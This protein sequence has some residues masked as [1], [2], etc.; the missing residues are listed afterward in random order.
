MNENVGGIVGR[1]VSNLQSRNL[2]RA[3]NEFHD[4]VEEEQQEVNGPLARVPAQTLRAM[5]PINQRI[6]NGVNQ[7]QAGT[8]EEIQRQHKIKEFAHKLYERYNISKSLEK[9]RNLKT[10]NIETSQETSKQISLLQ[11]KLN[12]IDLEVEDFRN[13]SDLSQQYNGSKSTIL[14]VLDSLLKNL[15]TMKKEEHEDFFSENI[16]V[17]QR[18]NFSSLEQFYKE[19]NTEV[20]QNEDCDS[21]EE[22]DKKLNAEQSSS[23]QSNIIVS[24]EVQQ[25]SYKINKLAHKLYEHYI[26]TET[27]EKLE[28]I[29]K[30]N[31]KELQGINDRISGKE[32]KLMDIDLQILKDSSDLSISSDDS[33]P[34][35]SDDLDSSICKELDYLVRTLTTECKTTKEQEDF[36]ENNKEK[37]QN[38]GFSSLEDFYAKINESEHPVLTKEIAEMIYNICIIANSEVN[39]NQLLDYNNIPELKKQ[40]DKFQEE[41]V[42][43]LGD[44]RDFNFRDTKSVANLILSLELKDTPEIK[45]QYFEQNKETFQSFG[46][47]SLEN[48]YATIRGEKD[49]E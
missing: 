45:K 12:D 38:I 30:G 6:G 7:L 5:I 3:A 22:F 32:N 39:L 18:F 44:L 41:N 11:N 24:P 25:E 43:L 49:P 20:S 17:F 48:F 31:I 10:L 42:K 36:F 29:K 4:V 47:T 13:D 9:L 21:Q 14:E 1:V 23:S 16:E 34:L 8:P 35:L 28:I 37:F 19:M 33:E 26:V 40:K 2:Q 27:L 15:A 46:F